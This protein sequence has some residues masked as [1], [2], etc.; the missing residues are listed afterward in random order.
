LSFRRFKG[1][2]DPATLDPDIAARGAVP[3]AGNPAGVLIRRS[4]IGSGN[5]HVRVAVPAVVSLM[6]SPVRVLVRGWRHYLVMRCRGPDANVNLC[7]RG[8]GNRKD[9]RK[10][11]SKQVLSHV[12]TPSWGHCPVSITAETPECDRKLWKKTPNRAIHW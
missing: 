8:R 12:V 6:P 5:P 11:G 1:L 9:R 7:P 3:V 2:T 10:G 4:D